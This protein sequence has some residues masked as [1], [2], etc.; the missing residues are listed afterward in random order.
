MGAAIHFN[1]AGSEY[2]PLAGNHAPVVITALAI[3]LAHGWDEV[4]QV[5]V[6]RLEHGI[7]PLA[8]FPARDRLATAF[9]A[10]GKITG[11]APTRAETAKLGGGENML[12]LDASGARFIGHGLQSTT[13]EVHLPVGA[14]GAAAVKR[15]PMI[16]VNLI[17]K[18]F[19]GTGKRAG[20][21][22]QVAGTGCGGGWYRAADT[23]QQ[24]DWEPG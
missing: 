2:P 14:V 23:R 8:T 12:S 24:E 6:R 22:G 10:F 16:E 19:S 3:D 17:V 7:D 15:H 11:L 18:R 4:K 9:D 20:G 13:G 5:I 21:A 1:V